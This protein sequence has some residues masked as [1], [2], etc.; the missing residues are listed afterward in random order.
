MKS[1]RVPVMVSVDVYDRLKAHARVTGR[2]ATSVIEEG[3]ED[4]L[5]TVGVAREQALTGVTAEEGTLA[6]AHT[7][8]A[9][10]A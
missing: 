10:R 9:G 3:L 5:Q 7:A 1:D 6:L 2:T 4:W 8:S